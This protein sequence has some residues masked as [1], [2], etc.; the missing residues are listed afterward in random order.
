MVCR[1]WAGKNKIASLRTNNKVKVKED[2]GTVS[3]VRDG[4][5]LGTGT[6]RSNSPWLGS[7]Q[8]ANFRSN[9]ADD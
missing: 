2:S 4:T 9:F 5:S 8:Q 1:F 3:D 7:A 6:S